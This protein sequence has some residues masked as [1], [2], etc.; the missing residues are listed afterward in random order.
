MNGKRASSLL[1]L[2]LE[3]LGFA[4][5]GRPI[6]D[7]VTLKVDHGGNT[8]ILGPNGAGK[9]VLLRLCHGLLQPTSGRVTW[10]GAT[11]ADDCGSDK[12]WC[13]SSRSC[14]DVPP[15]SCMRCRSQGCAARGRT[16]ALVR[17][18]VSGCAPSRSST[19]GRCR[20]RTAA[21]G[22]CA[23]R[24]LDPR[25]SSSTADGEPRSRRRRID[26]DRFDRAGRN[27]DHHDDDHLA[28]RDSRPKSFSCI[29]AA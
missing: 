26:A 23:R 9:S 3:A 27:Q 24:A 4:A 2:T 14:C 7:D 16:R 22:H 6:I 28:R 21:S 10:N 12:R 19:R 1:P 13:F 5:R 15:T 18:N 20:G 25:C 8:V 11:G 17:S 29:R